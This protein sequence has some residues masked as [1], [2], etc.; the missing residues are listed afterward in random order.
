[1]QQYVQLSESDNLFRHL[2]NS[3]LTMSQETIPSWEEEEKAFLIDSPYDN[4]EE[5]ENLES[6][7]K[8]HFPIT[9]SNIEL[10]EEKDDLFE[11]ST[12]KNKIEEITNLKPLFILKIENEKEKFELPDYFRIDSCIKHFK[13]AINQYIVEISNYFIAESP[14]FISSNER[15]NK[16]PNSI[17]SNCD[18]IKNFDLLFMKIKDILSFDKK[19]IPLIKKIEKSSSEISNIIKSF[20]E[21]KYEDAFKVFYDNKAIFEIFKRSKLTQFYEEKFAIANGFSLLENYGFLR[22]IKYDSFPRAKKNQELLAQ[23]REQI[24]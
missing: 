13:V 19:N 22:F 16:I 15:L 11:Y 20:L 4:S 9:I 14:E 3:I 21:F 1:M 18:Y 10:D 5:D 8:K 2:D 7:F 6:I 12:I 24:I 17:T 23:K